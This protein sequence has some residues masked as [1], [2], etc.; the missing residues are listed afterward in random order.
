[1]RFFRYLARLLVLL[2]PFRLL[3]RHK[4]RHYREMLRALCENRG[5]WLY[6]VRILRHGVCDGCS[7]GP[8]GLKDDV[9]PGTHL[10]LT[11]LKLLRLN[12]MGPIPDELLGDVSRLAQLSNEAL[13]QLGRVPY[14]L[15]R[16][17]GE[18][19]FSR[20]GWEEALGLRAGHWKK[21]AP[22]RVGV[23][24]ASRG[25]T[26]EGYYTPQK[27]ARIGGTPHVATCPRL[28]HA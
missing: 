6:A 1:M 15:L 4:P 27:L 9:L 23:F 18:R 2:V 25:L 11:R 26:N 10:C 14:P 21:A 8:R 17:R 7:L 13:H 5:R 22:E 12:T 3:S 24:L 28:C 16:R 20:I 19:G